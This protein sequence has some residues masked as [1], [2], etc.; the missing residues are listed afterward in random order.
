VTRKPEAWKFHKL[1][2]TGRGEARA[3]TPDGWRLRAVIDEQDGIPVLREI[4]IAPIPRRP[5]PAG[6][7]TA[8]RLRLFSVGGVL[9][10]MQRGARELLTDGRDQMHVLPLLVT[11]LNRRRGRRPTPDTML[12]R[13]AVR[14]AEIVEQGGAAPIAS[15][16]REFNYSTVRTRDLVK[17]ARDSGYLTPTKPGRAGGIAT[18]R[19]RILARLEAD[20]LEV[21][22]RVRR[23]K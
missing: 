13:I 16:A 17:Q 12:A 10:L 5:V 7:L 9:P 4:H 2:L 3:D 20:Q 21:M 23:S 6:G 15:L 1:S 8:R 11:N 18:E 22:K 19:A 14:Y